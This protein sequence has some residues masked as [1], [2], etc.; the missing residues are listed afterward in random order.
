MENNKDLIGFLPR[1]ISIE[2]DGGRFRA[3]DSFDEVA[4]HLRLRTNRDG[5]VYPPQTVSVV[6][7]Q[8]ADG[9]L[10]QD[11]EKKWEEVPNSERPALLHR[12]PAS[13]ELSISNPPVGLIFRESD[14]AFLMHLASYLFGVRLQFHDWWFDGRVPVVSTH[15]IFVTPQGANNFFS[16]SYNTWKNW[17]PDHRYLF[18]NILYMNSRSP[19]Y[20]WDWEQFII[21]YMVL[22][23]CYHISS[24][25]Y[26][27]KG[28]NDIRQIK[29]M[30]D[31]FGLAT[32]DS[33]IRIIVRLRHNLFHKALWDGSHPCTAIP[34]DAWRQVNMLRNLNQR[35]I[36]AIIRFDT[37]YINIP[38]SNRGTCLFA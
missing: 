37:E 15:N 30:C 24:K 31:H 28:N 21:D 5:Y 20:E 11:N 36:A 13:H 9:R 22:D 25:L 34:A 33:S 29:N 2:F 3:L 4:K 7:S 8:V 16:H 26:K 1:K 12:L 27:I 6:A 35:L 18:T 23:S 32:D 38:W 14:G 17:E 19:S 10:L